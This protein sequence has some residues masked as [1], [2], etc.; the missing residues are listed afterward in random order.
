MKLSVII[1]NYNVKFFLEQCLRSVYK[2]LEGIASEVIVVDNNSVDSSCQMIKNFF[3]DVILIENFQNVGYAKANN[4]AIKIAKGEYILLLNPD[5]I[6]QEDTFYK[7]I[8]FM[9]NTP[10][11]GALGVKMI[12][13]KGN[14]LPESKRSLPRPWVAFYKIFGLSSLFPRSKI[15]GQYHLSYLDKNEINKVEVLCGAFMFIR[16]EALD[17]AGLLDENFFMYGEDIDLSYRIILAGYNNYY[18]PK[19]TIIHYKG[20]STKKGSLNYV[21][22]FYN[23]MIIFAKKYFSSSKYKIFSFLIH[24]AIYFRAFISALKRAFLKIILPLTDFIVIY[25]G[26]LFLKPFSESIKFEGGIHYPPLFINFIVPSY[27]F[28]W[29]TALF[30]CGAYDKT[31]AC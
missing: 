3:P 28:V 20:E 19:T 13:G 17:K 8:E 26:Y 18:F 30:F 6:V 25:L 1:V 23:A 15:F 22:M 16:K 7:C 10:D 21:V 12:D 24:S 9:D 5:T 31:L 4:Q 29:I 2:A 14:F 11:A 27:I